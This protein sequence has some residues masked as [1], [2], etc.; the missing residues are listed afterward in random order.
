M[1]PRG[2]TWQPCARHAHSHC[3]SPPQVCAAAAAHGKAVPTV[4]NTVR[5]KDTRMLTVF[6][7][8][9]ALASAVLDGKSVSLTY[10]DGTVENV[11]LP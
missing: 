7:F 5:A 11:M 9:K 10:V 3:P 8:D 2:W 4:L 1:V 6:T